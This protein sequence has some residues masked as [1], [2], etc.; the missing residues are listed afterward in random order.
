VSSAID[1]TDQPAGTAEARCDAAARATADGD[2]TGAL[3]LVLDL[4]EDGAPSDRAYQIAAQALVARAGDA[5]ATADSLSGLGPEAEGRLFRRLILQPDVYAAPAALHLA[6]ASAHSAGTAGVLARFADAFAPTL[7]ALIAEG[8]RAPNLLTMVL[9]LRH[10]LGARVPEKMLADWHLCALPD[11]DFWHITIPYNAIFDPGRFGPNVAEVRAYLQSVPPAERAARVAPW[12]MAVMHWMLG[13]DAVDPGLGAYLA[14]PEHRRGG[15]PEEG[16]HAK[17][18]ASLSLRQAA[19]SGTPPAAPE[20]GALA[21]NYSLPQAPAAIAASAAQAR[22]RL[23]ARP[24]QAVAAA[25]TLAARSAPFLRLPWRRRPRIALCISGQ[26]RGYHA[27]YPTWQRGLLV[28]ADLR[29][30]VHSWHKIGRSG[31]EPFRAY[32]PFAGETFRETYR[33]EALTAGFETMVAR[34]PALFAGLRQGGIVDGAA[35]RAFY[36]TDHV[37]LDDDGG[38]PFAGWSN[39]RKM[40]HKIAAAHAMA[41]A[42]DAD[43]DLVLRLRPDKALGLRAFGWSDLQAATGDRCLFTD[44]AMGHQYGALFIGDQVA[45]GAPAAMGVYAG[46]AETGPELYAA[47]LFR[48]PDDF[49]GHVSLAMTCWHAGIRVE[50]LPVKMGALLEVERMAMAEIAAALETDAAGRMDRVD[51]ALLAA[52]RADQASGRA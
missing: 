13:G 11:V 28:G 37:Q 21:R 22:A 17:A 19:I 46:T 33:R 3:R 27:A 32:L 43:V 42:D 8:T 35:L 31:G 45:I 23:A 30:Y 52:L 34:Q 12:Q 49:V 20:L 4:F 2:A 14:A 44:F 41:M 5:S 15:E 29:T 39:S 51:R 47:G 7:T 16:D 40:H 36:G 38:A 1:P 48:A 50:R 9:L 25:A 18:L 6:L 10:E 24:R 26:L